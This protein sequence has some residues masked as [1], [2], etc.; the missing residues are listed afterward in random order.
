MTVVI[1]Q[2]LVCY[3]C[4]K[5]KPIE[6][7]VKDKSRRIGYVRTCRSCKKEMSTQYRIENP[8]QAKKSAREWKRRMRYAEI[9][10]SEEGYQELFKRQGGR[11]AIC[12]RK[13]K[14]RLSVDHDHKTGRV[15]GLLCVTCNQG[16]GYFKDDAST[17]HRAIAYVT[18]QVTLS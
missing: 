4:K 15:R 3:H 13:V 17:L 10:I 14:T 2:T 7:F 5:R 6:K 9:G 11:C 8:E 16:L 12:E 1:P 18:G